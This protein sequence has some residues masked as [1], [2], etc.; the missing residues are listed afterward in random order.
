VRELTDGVGVDVVLDSVGSTWPESVRCLR[1]GGRLVVFGAT[2]ATA[3]ELEV[4]RVYFG[5]ISILGTMMGSP[6]DFAALLRALEPDGVTPVIDSVRPLAE[7]ADA[8]ARIESGAHFGKLV[9]D[10]S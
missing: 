2:G 6:R 4:R 8:H 10:I 9:L 5:Q 3:V 7:A 1:A